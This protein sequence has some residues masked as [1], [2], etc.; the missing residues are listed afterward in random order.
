MA[1]STAQ[2]AEVG[3]I[4]ER[5]LDAALACFAR[6]GVRR[7]TMNSIADQAGVGVATVYRRFPKKEQLLQAVLVREATRLLDAVQCAIADV[8]TYDEQMVVG[9]VT[10]TQ[11]LARRTLLRKAA[12]PDVGSPISGLPEHESLLALGRAAIATIIRFWQDAGKLPS[13]DPEPVAEIFVRLGHSLAMTPAGVIP[14]VDADEAR[15]F[16]R[17]HLLPLVHPLPG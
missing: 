17:R 16:V 8:Q 3:E 11:E 5:V 6:A 1:V 4:T 2:N 13:Y 14:L 12:A 15:T 9:F 10:F 7:T